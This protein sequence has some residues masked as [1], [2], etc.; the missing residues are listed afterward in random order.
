[1]TFFPLKAQP[2]QR[3]SR[4]IK[5]TPKILANEELRQ[6]FELQNNARLSN[7]NEHLDDENVRSPPRRETNA[8]ISLPT[9]QIQPQPEL[10][11]S[12]KRVEKEETVIVIDDK[13]PEVTVKKSPPRT[14]PKRHSTSPIQQKTEFIRPTR[15]PC[16][17][18]ERLLNEIKMAKINLHRSPED[19]KKLNNKQKK[20]LN[21]M[22]ERHFFK[23][24]LQRV[25]KSTHKDGDTSGSELIESDDNEEFVPTQKINVGRPNVTLRVRGQKDILI[26]NKNISPAV[27]AAREKEKKITLRSPPVGATPSQLSPPQLLDRLDRHSKEL[28]SRN[29]EISLISSTKHKM[30]TEKR[31][32]NMQNGGATTQLTSE[33]TLSIRKD[34]SAAIDPNICT[35]NKVSKYYTRRTDDTFCSAIDQIDNQKIGCGNEVSGELLNLLRPSVRASYMLL[36]DSHKKRLYAHNCCASC[37]VFCT[38]GRFII[39]EKNHFFHQNCATKLIL[40]APYDPKNPNYSCPTLVLKCPHCG[41]DAPGHDSM[42]SMRCNGRNPVFTTSPKKLVKPARMSIGTHSHRTIKTRDESYL[43]DIERLVPD[44]IEAILVR[45][46]NGFPFSEDRTFSSKDVFYAVTKNDIERMAEIIGEFLI[47][48]Y[49]MAINATFSLTLTFFSCFS[50]ATF[51]S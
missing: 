50:F 46:Q 11:S 1:M 31:L 20:R 48:P 12:P 49:N 39:C 29:P 37:G 3:L 14:P 18:P 6:G 23:L 42:V 8:I 51:C 25:S 22:K 19:N 16:P 45:A 5:P 33:V 47:I 13:E 10:K 43:M 26:Y 7:S 9:P 36:C 15:R 17:D 32:N 44:T 41:S 30:T 28:I 34:P 2:Q 21:K 35:C 27:K 40:N 4:R 24:G 38:Q